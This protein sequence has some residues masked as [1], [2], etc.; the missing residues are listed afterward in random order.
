MW[1]RIYKR[2]DS[3]EDTT[4]LVRFIIQFFLEKRLMICWN[5]YITCNSYSTT[6]LTRMNTACS[7]RFNEW[8][9]QFI[10][11]DQVSKY[12]LSIINIS[13]NLFIYHDQVQRKRSSI[14]RHCASRQSIVLCFRTWTSFTKLLFLIAVAP[15]LLRFY[16]ATNCNL[17][18]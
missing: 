9:N 18:W 14:D 12:C 6:T 2:T 13:R 3:Y 11:Q 1:I 16:P 7:W 17:P 15:D 10:C 5:S 4:V 8:R